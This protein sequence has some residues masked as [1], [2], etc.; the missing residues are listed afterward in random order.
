MKFV[1]FC[2][3]SSDD[4][5][6][7]PHQIRDGDAALELFESLRLLKFEH[8]GILIN[9]PFTDGIID[10]SMT[11]FVSLNMGE[12]DVL[13]LTTRPPLDDREEKKPLRPSGTELERKIFAV[14]REKCFAECSRSTV[15]VH[16]HIRTHFLAN[17]KN[18]SEVKYYATRLKS[19]G[20]VEDEE[21]I[22]DASYKEL[23][24]RDGTVL[25]ETDMKR[26]SAGYV[27]H[28]PLGRGMPRL[29]AVFGL[30]GTMTFLWSYVL[31]KTYNHLLDWVLEYPKEGSLNHGRFIMA[32]I[33]TT[34]SIPQRPPTL[35]ACLRDMGWSDE[36]IAQCDF[37]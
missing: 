1:R 6:R 29:L 3:L 19:R 32:E 4:R 35:D 2:Y 22:G 20:E 16:P 27:V 15:A 21:L 14:L 37:N 8:G 25:S 7:F 12:S 28:L 5:R 34:A 36:I 18:R 26:R 31:S 17:Y 13:L 33:T 24:G 30:S 10:T 23:C 11:D 9:W